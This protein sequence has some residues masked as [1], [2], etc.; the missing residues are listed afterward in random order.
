[1]SNDA[2]DICVICHDNLGEQYVYTLPECNHKF[3][4]NCIMTPGLEPNIILVLFA[5]IK[6]LMQHEAK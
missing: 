4:T 6:V 3:H 1:M 5:I 2:N